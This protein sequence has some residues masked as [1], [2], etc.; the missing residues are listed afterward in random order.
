MNWFKC[1]NDGNILINMHNI[2]KILQNT[3]IPNIKKNQTDILSAIQDVLNSSSNVIDISQEQ[4]NLIL[5]AIQSIPSD[6]IVDNQNN[7]IS[8]LNISKSNTDDS[9]VTLTDMY[10]KIEYSVSGTLIAGETSITLK[11][12]NIK[13]DTDLTVYTSQY[14]L[15]PTLMS[16][17]N[18][19]VT[20]TFDEQTKDLEV[21]V[22][23]KRDVNWTKIL[24]VPIITT[25]DGMEQTTEKDIIFNFSKYIDENVSTLP[26]S[27]YG[28]SAVVLNNEIHILGGSN[29]SSCYTKHY[30]YDGSAWTSVSTLPYNFYEGS[31]VVLNN[32]IHILG[33][34]DSSYRTKHYTVA[35]PVYKRIQ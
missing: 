2:L 35:I 24:S 9:K 33:S 23:F 30:K 28:G 17:T 20:L 14:N 19:S 15:T 32:E 10:K 13:E 5:S 25:I 26:Y 29:D 22:T 7:I 4:L 27:F 12:N 8:G 3:S 21:R 18:G 34:Y 16:V 31:A 6:T 11:D 1:D